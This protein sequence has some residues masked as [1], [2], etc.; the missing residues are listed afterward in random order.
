MISGF[1]SDESGSLQAP[2]G[3]AEEFGGMS[4]GMSYF[5]SV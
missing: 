3:Q 2:P 4:G 5:E 1:S